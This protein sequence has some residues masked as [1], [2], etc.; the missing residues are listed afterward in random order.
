MHILHFFDFSFGGLGKLREAYKSLPESSALQIRSRKYIAQPLRA[1]SFT[2]VKPEIATVATSSLFNASWAQCSAGIFGRT[3]CFA[4]TLMTLAAWR[5][6]QQGPLLSSVNVTSISKTFGLSDRPTI[7]HKR[8]CEERS[9]FQFDVCEM[10]KRGYAEIHGLTDLHCIPRNAL[11]EILLLW[12]AS[13]PAPIAV[14]PAK[15]I[16]G[17]GVSGTT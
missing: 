17:H 16:S 9:N 2:R 13:A 11:L 6:Y 10:P 1:T 4:S 15:A 8:E 3:S 5:E 12:K 14:P 7:A